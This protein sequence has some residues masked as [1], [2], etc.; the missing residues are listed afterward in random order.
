[1]VGIVKSGREKTDLFAASHLVR[2][3]HKA[4]IT[5]GLNHVRLWGKS[6]HE[7]IYWLTN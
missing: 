5:I 4:D 6:G 1:M 7:A 2:F 3:W